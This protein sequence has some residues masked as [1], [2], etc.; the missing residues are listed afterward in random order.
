MTLHS[1]SITHGLLRP[2]MLPFSRFAQTPLL[3]LKRKLADR[4]CVSASSFPSTRVRAGERN[5]LVTSEQPAPQ[6]FL[7]Q[8]GGFMIGG[9]VVAIG[10]A[11]MVLRGGNKGSVDRLAERGVGL[12]KERNV[13]ADKFY[14]G[15]MKNVR[16]TNM[17]ELTDE[18][19]R[20]ARDRRK[21]E[22]V[23]TDDATLEGYLNHVEVPSNHPWAVAQEVSPEEE[24]ER[25]AN[26]EMQSKRRKR[27]FDAG[28]GF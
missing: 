12:E 7:Q 14:E 17:P 1:K 3:Q 8:H 15:M 5:S 21:Q 9:V 25:Q 2:H 11:V 28:S 20:A 27:K 23:D 19:I 22:Q 6:G 13:D 10:L 24:A 26:L 16:T 4:A 18:Q